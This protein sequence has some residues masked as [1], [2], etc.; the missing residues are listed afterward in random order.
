MVETWVRFA[1]SGALALSVPDDP[2]D[3]QMMV[4]LVV[5][6]ALEI[7]LANCARIGFLPGPVVVKR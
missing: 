2:R 6:T 5:L 7:A 4:A 1:Q 3:R